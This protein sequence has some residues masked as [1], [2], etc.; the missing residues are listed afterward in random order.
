MARTL[1][2]GPA[3][4][5]VRGLEGIERTVRDLARQLLDAARHPAAQRGEGQRGDLLTGSRLP[6]PGELAA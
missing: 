4:Q 5:L 2:R 6:A 1:V 3:E